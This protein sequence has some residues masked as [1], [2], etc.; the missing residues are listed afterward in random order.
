MI[1]ISIILNER[2]YAENAINNGYISKKPSETLSILA[3]Y[4]H[5]QG[6][7]KSVIHKSLEE[8]MEKYYPNFNS[9][10]WQLTI[11][12]QVKQVEKY[13]LI[14]I[15]NVII[16]ENEL[17]TIR[18]LKNKSL[19]KL[20]FTLLCLAKFSNAV[21]PHN[22][23][24]SN[25]EDKEIFK[26]A[27]IQ[28]DI[29][30]QSLMMN[31]L[32]TAGL[33]EYSR[34]VDNINSHILFIDTDSLPILFVDDFRDLGFTY[35]IYKGENFTRCKD[36]GRIIRQNKQNNIVYCND[37]KGYQSIGTKTIICVDCSKETV[38]KAWDMKTCRCEECQKK[39][40]RKLKTELQRKYRSKM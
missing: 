8:F 19:E 1:S 38:V 6:I 11:E 26:L 13:S 22:N 33:I 32:K 29:K 18:E 25:R 30:K 27:N 9:A 2:I 17:T 39:Y 40:N 34:I 31:D 3:K 35:L 36:C 28:A 37:C 24:W 12:K 20:A 16:T 7:K 15:D 14:E 5:K 4:Y 10:K 23:D 21:N